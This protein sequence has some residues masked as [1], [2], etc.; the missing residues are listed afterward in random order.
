M[1]TKRSL[2]NRSWKWPMRRSARR[3]GYAGIYRLGEWFPLTISIGNDGPDL[4]GVL[5]W[6]FI[7]QPGE[8]VFRQ[9]IDLPSGS[10]K[11]VML[12]RPPERRSRET[13]RSS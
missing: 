4:R 3:A 10:R 2:M 6:S 12:E 13:G 5:E 11:R 8:Q 9:A 7:G 1:R